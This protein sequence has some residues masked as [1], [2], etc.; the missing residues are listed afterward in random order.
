MNVGPGVVRPAHRSGPPG[1]RFKAPGEF[2]HWL[3]NHEPAELLDEVLRVRSS[4][5][6]P[7]SWSVLHS[8]GLVVGR[9]TRGSLAGEREGRQARRRPRALDAGPAVPPARPTTGRTTAVPPPGLVDEVPTRTDAYGTLDD[10][11]A[12]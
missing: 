7:P 11:A 12:V 5:S 2:S 9:A 8:P 3:E 1:R 6:G 4:P 10:L